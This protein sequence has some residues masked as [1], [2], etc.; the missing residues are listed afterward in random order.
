MCLKACSSVF[1]W[2][3]DRRGNYIWL[4]SHLLLF[5]SSSNNFLTA[6][7]C[8]K[9]MSNSCQ[10]FIS[11]QLNVDMWQRKAQRKIRASNILIKTVA[12]AIKILLKNLHTQLWI[13]L[14]LF[15]L[16]I[17][18]KWSYPTN[19]FS[20]T[21]PSPLQPTPQLQYLVM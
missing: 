12:P 14:I 1:M 19:S 7:T 6:W 18:K 2:W 21:I 9:L 16:L 10:L 13:K 15:S 4:K 5:H 11:W 8:I 20:F 17:K 3:Q